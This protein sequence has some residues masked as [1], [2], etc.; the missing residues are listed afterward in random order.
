VMAKGCCRTVTSGS[1]VEGRLCGQQNK[2]V[3]DFTHQLILS[4]LCHHQCASD[5]FAPRLTVDLFEIHHALRAPQAS[6]HPPCCHPRNAHAGSV[7]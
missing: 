1:R 4:A 3:T 7:G 2:M 5:I 6:Y